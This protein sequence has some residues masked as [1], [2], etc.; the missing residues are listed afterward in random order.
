MSSEWTLPLIEAELDSLPL[1][2]D[3]ILAPDDAARLFGT[4]GAATRQIA[5]F[6]T[7]HGCRAD[8]RGDELVFRKRL[9]PASQDAVPDPAAVECFPPFAP[10]PSPS[11]DDHPGAACR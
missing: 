2:C 6:A 8:T 11:G 4:S 7:A 3:F 1:G 9:P 10:P 5:N